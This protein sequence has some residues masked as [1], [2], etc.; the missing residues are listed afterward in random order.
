M[1]DT[2]LRAEAQRKEFGKDSTPSRRGY[3][4]SIAS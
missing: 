4:M 3:R 2:F 1:G